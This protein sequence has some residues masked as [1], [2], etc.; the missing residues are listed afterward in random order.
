LDGFIPSVLHPNFSMR[1]LSSS[2]Q[3]DKV[4][5]VLSFAGFIDSLC[6]LIQIFLRHGVP[7]YLSATSWTS[8]IAWISG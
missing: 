4:V 5:R 7:F 1:V 2:L 3:V 8:M 6:V